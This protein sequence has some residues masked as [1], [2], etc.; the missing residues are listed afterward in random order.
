VLELQRNSMEF[1]APCLPCIA[2]LP[3]SGDEWLHEIKHPGRRIIA[4]R[5]GQYIRLFAGDG[6]D[7]TSSFPVL[8][9][10]MSLLPVRSCIID[11]DLVRGDE[12][13]NPQAGSLPDAQ[14]EAGASLYTFDL[15]EVNGFDL[16]RDRIEDRKYA[17]TRV[18][19]NPPAA[20]GFNELFD[21]CGEPMLRQVA[22]MGFDGIVSKRRGSRYLSGRSPDWLFSRRID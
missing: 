20:I 10:S 21:S 16:R 17:L 19:R 6:Q 5:N 4:R 11:G 18:L 7:W 1:I 12:H 15:L 2:M 9:E 14:P 3:P 8:V 22:R 13:G